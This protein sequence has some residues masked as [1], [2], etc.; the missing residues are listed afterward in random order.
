MRE[1]T[2]SE[3]RD[4]LERPEELREVWPDAVGDR[5]DVIVPR[6]LERDGFRFVADWDAGLRLAGIAYGY[7]GAPG[8]W[9]H[10]LVLRAMDEQARARWRS[11]G[12]GPAGVPRGTS[13]SSSW[14][15]ARTCGDRASAAGCT[16][17]C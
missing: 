9:W 1:L 4:L 16:T 12:R 6:H 17:R 14:Q 8:Q 5:L 15:C 11:P 3:V 10:D 13:S 2:R 7:R